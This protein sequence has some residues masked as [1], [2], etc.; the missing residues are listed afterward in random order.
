MEAAQ[1]F[2]RYILI[3]ADHTGCP[4]FHVLQGIDDNTVIRTMTGSLHDDETRKTHFVNENFFL[5]LPGA[6]EWFVFRFRRQRKAIKW[7]DHMHVSIDRAFRQ[8]ERQWKR[9]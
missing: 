6:R 4:S 9:A 8:R 3:K 5:F 1:F 2:D 7:T